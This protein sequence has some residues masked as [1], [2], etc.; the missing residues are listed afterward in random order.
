[1][2]FRKKERN[3]EIIFIAP[4]LI[5]EIFP[6]YI[7]TVDLIPVLSLAII[8]YTV[9][10]MYISKLLG[11]EKSK[12]VIIG[13][14]ITIFVLILGIFIFQEIFGAIGLAIAVVLAYSI[15]AVYLIGI[16]F[17]AVKK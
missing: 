8:P 1:L 5:Q 6:E 12:H 13:Y 9:S 11:Q 4:Q 16:N 7:E 15:Q 14:S 3:R 2:C 10:Y 17:C